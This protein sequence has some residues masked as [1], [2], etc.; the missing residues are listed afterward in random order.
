MLLCHDDRM[1][2]FGGFVHRKRKHFLVNILCNNFRNFVHHC[3][4]ISII[5]IGQQLF[6]CSL[7]IRR[8]HNFVLEIVKDIWRKKLIKH[9][10]LSKII[11]KYVGFLFYNSGP[12]GSG[13]LLI[14][15]FCIIFF[16][17]CFWYD[18]FRNRLNFF[19]LSLKIAFSFLIWVHLWQLKIYIS[20]LGLK[21][22]VILFLWFIFF[23]SI[24]ILL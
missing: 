14:I 19:Y 16:F 8:Y 6:R 7:F 11:F 22:L 4:K 1:G 15:S 20:F 12:F 9:N 3:R 23:F 2:Y 21:E 13:F 10:Y 18:N 24:Y 5:F 17:V